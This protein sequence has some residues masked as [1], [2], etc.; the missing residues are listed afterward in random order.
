MKFVLVLASFFFATQVYAKE[1]M[2][3][4]MGLEGQCDEETTAQFKKDFP[5]SKDN[6]SRACFN[7]YIGSAVKNERCFILP[8]ET[9]TEYKRLINPI[10]RNI[11]YDIDK[12]AAIA[13]ARKA[14]SIEELEKALRTNFK[15]QACDTAEFELEAARDRLEAAK[16]D[17]AEL[18]NTVSCK[19]KVLKKE[20]GI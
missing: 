1:E 8:G 10:A 5:D 16:N 17:Y 19:N 3:I 20:K 4:G 9:A 15:K 7:R 2:S 12:D 14:K 11:A 13:T 6:C 18:S